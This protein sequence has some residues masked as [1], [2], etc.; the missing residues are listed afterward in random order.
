M[1]LKTLPVKVG[2]FHM[3]CESTETGAVTQQINNS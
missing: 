2:I 3:K 1:L